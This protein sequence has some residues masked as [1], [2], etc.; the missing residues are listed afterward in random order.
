[1]DPW[2]LKDFHRH[3]VS[4]NSVVYRSPG[5][6]SP[7]AVLLFLKWRYNLAQY[8]FHQIQ[9]TAKTGITAFQDEPVKGRE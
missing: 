5:L 9:S 2:S 7:G 1:M 8:I 6:Y 3:Q 4:L